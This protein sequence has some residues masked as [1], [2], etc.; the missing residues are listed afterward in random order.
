[1]DPQ[2]LYYTLSTIAQTLAGALAILVAVVLFRLGAR[3]TLIDAAKDTLRSQ[4]VAPSVY[5][6]VMRDS[7]YDAMA[8]EVEKNT[9]W[10]L[11]QN[12]DLRRVCEAAVAAYREWGRISPRLYAALGFTVG[13]I[14]LCFIALPLTPHV[15]CSQ[16]AAW[17]VLLA[18]IGLGITC[19]G[20]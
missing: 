19:L 4:S 17:A 20:L 7:G 6:P 5:W 13:D 1:M 9:A 14:A 16:S 11:H 3:R 8:K 2:A 15:A 12:V 10:H 18:A